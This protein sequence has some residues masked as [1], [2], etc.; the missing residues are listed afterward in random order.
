LHGFAGNLGPGSWIS[1]VQDTIPLYHTE[2]GGLTWNPVTNITGFH[3]K[4]ICGIRVVDDSVIYAVG[5]YAGPC[6]FLKTTDGGQDWTATNFSGK[7]DDLIDVWFFSRDTGIIVGG[8]NARSAIYYTDNGGTTWQNVF[9]NP[10][11]FGWHWKISFPSRYVGYTSIEGGTANT[12]RVAKTTDGGLTW[13]LKPLIPPSNG[14][15]TGIG[16]INDSVG[17]VGCWIPGEDYMTT[18]GGETWTLFSLDPQFNRFRKINDST[19]YICGEKVWKY[20]TGVAVGVTEINYEKPGYS[21]E[22]NFPNPFTGKTTIRYTIPEK[23]FVS[24]KVFDAAGRTLKT[25]VKQ[26]Q[27]KG[28]YSYNFSLPESTDAYF[29]CKLK[30]N[31]YQKIIK[32]VMVKGQE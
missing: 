6:A 23:G 28:S 27:E 13:Q 9:T 32:M 30:V 17:W 18:D 24:L 31:G 20:S 5:R 4:G 21:L 7:F 2:D 19:A 1:G 10:E 26:N 3:P 22:Q 29:I 8:N 11:P 25:F 12:S 14:D 16:F 15:A